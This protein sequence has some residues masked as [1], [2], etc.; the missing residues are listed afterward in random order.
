MNL[1]EEILREHNKTHALEIAH[2]A[3]SSTARF[4]ELMDC[5]LQG[6]YRLSQ[7]AAWSMSWAAREKP[8]MIQPYIKD[9]VAQLQRTDVHPS[10]IRNAVRI[11][12]EVF[13]PEEL[14]GEVM[15][16][17]FG[18]IEN[19][20]TPVAIK[21]FSLTTLGNLATHYPDIMPE[22]KLIIEERWEHE[23]AAFKTRAKKVLAKT[24]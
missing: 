4:K 23:T 21:A 3:C 1:R 24:K 22:L 5:F 16:A 18:F 9:L 12:Q 6:E 2:Y 19:P 7:R 20:A 14:H 15:N 17:C 11:L 13:I 10:V 8:A